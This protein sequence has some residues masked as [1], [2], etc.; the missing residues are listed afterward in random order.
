MLLISRV[1]ITSGK[2]DSREVE[3]IPYPTSASIAHFSS[4]SVKSPYGVSGTMLESGKSNMNM[5][6]T[7]L[8]IY[9][10]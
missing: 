3:D 8:D 10:D 9:S 1:I 5:T 6:T 2:A 4:P 7:D